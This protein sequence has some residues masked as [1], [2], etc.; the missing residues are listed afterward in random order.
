MKTLIMTLICTIT[1]TISTAQVPELMG[2]WNII[3]FEVIND[4]NTNKRTE[5]SLRKDGAVWDLFI[6][7][8]SKFKQTSNMRTGSIESHE[9]EWNDSE[10]LLTFKILVNNQEINLVYSY[11]LN[12]NILVI[13]R[14]NPKGTLRII[15]KFRKKHS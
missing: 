7:E 6:M 3:E 8:E 10:N 14:N 5:T 12:E 4:N 9:G 2:S 11:E 15:A 1:F 13:E